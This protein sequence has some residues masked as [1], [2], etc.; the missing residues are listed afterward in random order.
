LAE[1]PEA[2]PGMVLEPIPPIPD[3]AEG[4]TVERVNAASYD[5]Y[6]EV[7]AETGL[8]S[9][10]TAIAFPR[11]LVDDA[12]KAMFIGRLDG[13][14]AANSFIVR[15]GSTAGIYAVGTAEAARRRGLGNA[16]TWAAIGA[17]REWGCDA[18]VLQASEM[19]YPVYS[20]M[21]FKSVVDYAR[22]MPAETD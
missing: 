5:E 10:W 7:M 22:F 4:V 17:A 6:V 3:P 2:M 15:T 18:V 19:G 9:V 16:V 8:P 14:P 12:D 20:K 1:D 21:G 13:L 11:R